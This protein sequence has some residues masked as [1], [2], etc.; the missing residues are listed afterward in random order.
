MRIFVTRYD[1]CSQI[2]PNANLEEEG[3]KTKERIRK[4]TRNNIPK[5]VHI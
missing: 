5:G 3:R 2:E 4:K 1:S